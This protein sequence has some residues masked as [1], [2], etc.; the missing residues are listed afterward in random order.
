MGLDEIIQGMTP[1]LFQS[2]KGQMAQ[3]R[4]RRDVQGMG[5]GPR[6]NKWYDRN[7][8]KKMIQQ[9]ES[10]PQMLFLMDKCFLS[11]SLFLF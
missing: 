4:E 10:S 3:G 7:Q 11:F 5:R 1:G 6:G 9:R 2:F 8:A